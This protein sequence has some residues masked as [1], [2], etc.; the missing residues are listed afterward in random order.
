MVFYTLSYSNHVPASALTLWCRLLGH[1][2]L[3]GLA[4][5][6]VEPVHGGDVHDHHHSEGQDHGHQQHHDDTRPGRTREERGAVI[7]RPKREVTG[8]ELELKIV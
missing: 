8:H 3:D 5:G 1:V 7:S 6:V 4:L 2:D